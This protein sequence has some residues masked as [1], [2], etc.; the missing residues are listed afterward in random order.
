MPMTRFAIAY[1]ERMTLVHHPCDLRLPRELWAKIDAEIGHAMDPADHAQSRSEVI[2]RIIRAYFAAQS[3]VVGQFEIGGRLT[4]RRSGVILKLCQS[5]QAN[6]SGRATQTSS[7]RPSPMRLL[8]KHLSS[9][10]KSSLKR[11]PRP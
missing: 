6:Q 4:G 11:T 7:P 9:P 8:G 1:P 10:P 3:W 5:A 2:E